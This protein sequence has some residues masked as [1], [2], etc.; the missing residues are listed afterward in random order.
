MPKKLSD[1]VIAARMIELR[2]LRRLHTKSR[3]RELL[4]D[5]RIKELESI[6]IEQQATIETLKIQMAELQTMVFGRKK[7]P[8][9]GTPVSVG[10]MN[11]SSKQ[12]RNKG[13]YRRPLPP[14]SAITAT[15][16]IS[17]NRCECGGELN[18]ITMHERYEEDI[19][20]PNL[21]TDYQPKLIKK[22]TVSRGVCRKCGKV[23][24]GKDLGGQAVRLGP[25]VRIL[26]CHLVSAMGMSYTQVT[27]LLSSLYDLHI[28]DGE[29]ALILRKKHQVWLSAYEQLKA[30]IRAA[31]VVHVDE[32]PWP[33]QRNDGL[34]YAWT[35]SDASGKKVCF[36]LESSRGAIH[37]RHLF[38]T[39]TDSQFNGV[40]ISD[41]YAA[42]R[43]MPGLQQLC[44][45]H[46][47]RCIRD[48]RY[49]D[50]LPEEQLPNVSLWYK[51]FIGIYQ[52]LRLYLDESYDA[53]TRESQSKELWQR[54]QLLLTNN[55]KNEPV[56]LTK[57]KAQLMRAGQLKL[58]TCLT[59]NT[60][61]DN[62][63]AERDL[64]QLVLKR[65]RSFGS[66]TEKGAKALSTVLSICTTTWRTNPTGYFKALAQLG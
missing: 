26:I 39:G 56:K 20:L 52:D 43:T 60:P 49:N 1:S 45:A 2:N 66:Q 22:Y 6:V 55:N 38:G 33:I 35:L 58:F 13:S 63:R 14:V 65:K 48:L 4:K 9:T 37:A 41:D 64:R 16:I 7:R 5:V 25:N 12:P 3:Q 24:S 27:N 44:W 8:P 57:L 11:G 36:A 28:T 59:H 51:Q 17:V 54:L 23:I 15:E 42:Y 19:P 47:Y 34:G 32:T 53:T 61:C 46:L 18:H 21:T 10:V 29:I 62:N 30:D 40:R 50:N 31:P